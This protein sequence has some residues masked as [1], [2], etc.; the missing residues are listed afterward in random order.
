MTNRTRITDTTLVCI[1]CKQYGH[2]LTAIKKSIEQCE[3]DRV[4]FITDRKFD[5]DPEIETVII[6]KINSKEEYSEF[7]IKELYKYIDTT[8]MVVCQ[9][10]GYVLNGNAWN[11]DWKQYDYIGAA[12]L[13]TDGRNCGNGGF[14]LRTTRLMK[15]IATDSIIDCYHPEDSIICRLY[16]PYLEK[17]NG[18]KFAPDEVCDAFSFELREPNQPTFGFHGNFHAPYAPT[19]I[20]KRSGALGDIITMEP[21]MHELAMKGYN[22]VVDCPVH[23]FEVF[24]N[25]WYPVRHISE[26]DSGRIPATEIDLDMAY[27][28]KPK[29]LHLKS[30]FELVGIEPKEYRNSVLTVGNNLK[31][32]FNKYVVLHIDERDTPERNITGIDWKP[33]VSYLENN[34]YTVLQIGS[35]QHE[36]VATEINT[37]T[38]SFLKWVIAGADMFIGVDS[39]PAQIAVACGVESVVFFGSVDSKY[40]YPDLTDIHVIEVDDACKTPKCWASQITTNGVPCVEVNEGEIPPCTVF[41][42]AQV[43]KTLKLIVEN[44]TKK[45]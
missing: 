33:L 34:G 36:V 25:H 18:I 29:Q 19:V 39:G 16:R 38:T 11:E 43:F 28:V 12:W 21:V 37:P 6:P 32:L 7:V 24:G 31:K 30:Y 14:S 20:L 9:A 1:D 10:D 5:V 2:A 4:V 35:Q 44:Q 22:V 41:E 8:Y 42:Q 40:I 23:L 27:E 17:E 26:F 3:F 15:L 13:E 45:S